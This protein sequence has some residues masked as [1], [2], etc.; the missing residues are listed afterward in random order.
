MAK[1]PSAPFDGRCEGGNSLPF[2]L[3]EQR[4]S[5]GVDDAVRCG[6]LGCFHCREAMR[7]SFAAEVQPYFDQSSKLSLLTLIPTD[8]WVACGN[9]HEFDLGAFVRRHLQRLQRV[10]GHTVL[11]AGAIDISLCVNSNVVSHWQ[12]HLHAIVSARDGGEAVERL[13]DAY[14]ADAELEIVRPVLLVPVD[15]ASLPK[16]LGYI[17]KSDFSRRSRFL[18]QPKSGRAPYW[19][20]RIQALKPAERRELDHVLSAFDVGD[21]LCFI[22]LKR[23]RSADPTKLSLRPSGTRKSR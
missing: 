11:L 15:L 20:T 3:I 18:A 10:M 22:G 19:D 21:T 12:F 7:Q 5:N 8:G 23:M 2:G 14:P 9:L 6:S 1:D 4:K 17:Y 16:R 13:R